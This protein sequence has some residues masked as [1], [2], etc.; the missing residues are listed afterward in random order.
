[1]PKASSLI[2][3]NTRQV[4]VRRTSLTVLAVLAA[5]GGPT[6]AVALA[7]SG[8][9]AG[10]NQYV[11]PLAGTST[12]KSKTSTTHSATGTTPAAPTST[13]SATPAV[14]PAPVATTATSTATT[15]ATTATSTDASLPRTGDDTWLI[16][17]LG[18]GMAGAG[19]VLRRRAAAR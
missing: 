2:P 13:I 10:D 3:C 6:S 19:V 9:S 12:T 1:L 16:A 7:D 14:T 11:D 8:P 18:V 15:A 5:A 17:V 4:R